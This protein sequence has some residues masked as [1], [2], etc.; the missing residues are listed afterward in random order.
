MSVKSA[1][2]AQGTGPV[3]GMPADARASIRVPVERW[4]AAV[5][6]AAKEIAT[7]A[8]GYDGIELGGAETTRETTCGAYI[9]LTG[10]NNSLQIGLI[11]DAA[12]CQALASALLGFG[13]SAPPPVPADVADAVGEIVNMLA[14]GVK[15]RMLSEVADLALGLPIFVNGTIE[16]TDHLEVTAAPLRLGPVAA[17]VIILRHR[18]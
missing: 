14:G 5:R 9:P 18:G 15:R 2:I 7:C 3:S 10:A 8:L 11:S 16:R 1:M 6:S 4:L 12:G 13:A 17:S